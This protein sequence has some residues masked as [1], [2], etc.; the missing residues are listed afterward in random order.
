MVRW[1]EEQR[2][3][4]NSQKRPTSVRYSC[5]MTEPERLRLAEEIVEWA[6][7]TDKVSST[8]LCA[9]FEIYDQC[10]RE[11]CKITP[12]LGM[13]YDTVK[14]IIGEKRERMALEGKWNSGIVQM[15]M[16]IYNK[17]LREWKR[18]QLSSKEKASGGAAGVIQVAMVKM[19]E[20]ELVPL[21]CEGTE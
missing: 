21:R 13:A 20:T 9:D 8:A 3:P 12:E 15:M 4:T 16:P 14:E 19:P 1:L 10:F 17:D 5:H 11:W 7:H 6:K 2:D 18:E